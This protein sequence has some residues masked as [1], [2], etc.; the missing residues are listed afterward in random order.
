MAGKLA[1]ESER[2]PM[3]CV[4]RL[5]AV[6]RKELRQLGRDRLTFGMIA[7]I[8]LLQVMLFGYAINTDV[9]HLRAGVANQAGSE[10][11]R[12][13]V[14]DAAASQVVTLT[15]SVPTSD[16]LLDL[17]RRG[18]ITVGIAIPPDFERRLQQPDRPAAQLLLDGSDPVVLGA[19]R[20]LSQMTLHQDTAPISRG[21]GPL[22]GVYNPYNPA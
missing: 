4:T 7:G 13:L 15:R 11:S 1:E 20:Q 22:F 14:A 10:L 17:L 19:A 3:S 2:L 21:R 16:D 6:M 8:P 9:R 12:E 18:E 5:F